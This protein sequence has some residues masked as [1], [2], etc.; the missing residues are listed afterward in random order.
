[1]FLMELL[2]LKEIKNAMLYYRISIYFQ[3]SP[4][5]KTYFALHIEREFSNFYL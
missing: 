3:Y 4:H 1:M 5:I 2:I